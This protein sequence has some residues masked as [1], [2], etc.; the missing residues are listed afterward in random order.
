M[1]YILYNKYTIMI[2]YID[3]EQ[4]KKYTFSFPTKWIDNIKKGKKI[5]ENDIYTKYESQIE[6]VSGELI[7]CVDLTRLDGFCKKIIKETYQDY[8]QFISQRDFKKE[9]WVYN[10]LDGITEQDKILYRDEQ[11]VLLPNY[12][13][14]YSQN[15]SGGNDFTD[16]DL[17]QMY[18]LAFPTDKS[19]H[20]IRDL[21]GSHIDLLTHIQTKTNQIIKSTFGFDS[22]II[23]S[24]VH[25]SPTTYHLHIHWVLISNINVNSS[26]EYSHSLSNIITNLLVKNDYYQ[27]VELNKRI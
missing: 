1:I 24:F 2:H 22:N 11:F 13:W 9:Q 6:N 26:V 17:S 15:N 4:N 25:Y 8:I 3:K 18:L 23:K 27:I 10:I 16:I 14:K 7:E 5:F 12:T 20:S 21:N 19:I